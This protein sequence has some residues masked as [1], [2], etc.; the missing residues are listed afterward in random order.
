VLEFARGKIG[1]YI[2]AKPISAAD[3]VAAVR[4]F[5]MED[6][7]VVYGSMALHR[8]V[9]KMEPRIKVMPEAGSV[10][11]ASR[12]MGELRPRVVAFDARDFRDEIIAVAREAKAGIYV[13][14]LG[15][16]DTPDSWKMRSAGERPASRA[17]TRRSW[18]SFC[19]RRNSTSS[20]L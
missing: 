19:A 15:T 1:V 18:W 14:R 5:G 10:A 20:V 2:D 8:G 17:I 13:D 6:Q 9:Q 12:F 16:A 4:K 11:N 3:L 7:V